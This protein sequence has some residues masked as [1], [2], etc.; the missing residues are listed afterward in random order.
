MEEAGQVPRR[1][2]HHLAA[3]DA[4]EQAEVLP[5]DGVRVR[6]DDDSRV[7]LGGRTLAS[8]YRGMPDHPAFAEPGW[9]RTDDA[10]IVDQIS[11]AAFFDWANRL[12]LSLGEPEVP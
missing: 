11:G 8:G 9:F 6:V 7:W 12:M 10:G 3:A 2:G 1:V 5:L 4:D